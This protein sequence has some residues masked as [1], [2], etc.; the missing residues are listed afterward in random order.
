MRIILDTETCN[1]KVILNTQA[2]KNRKHN[3][4]VTKD[5]NKKQNKILS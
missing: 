3:I 5:A 2:A 4:G 1:K